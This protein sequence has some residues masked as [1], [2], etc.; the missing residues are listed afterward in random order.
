MDGVTI[1]HGAIIH[2]GI[3]GENCLIGMNSVVM[4]DV[5]MGDECIV[6]ACGQSIASL[7]AKSGVL[8]S[9]R[10]EQSLIAYCCTIVTCLAVIQSI[11]AYRYITAASGVLPQRK[12]AHCCI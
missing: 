3:I 6:G 11:S 7:I 10:I 9:S 2:G 8:T 4:D 12:A 5:V 1:G